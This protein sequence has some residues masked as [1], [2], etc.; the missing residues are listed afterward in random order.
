MLVIKNFKC[1]ILFLQ[2]ERTPVHFAAKDGH[3]EVIELLMK[4]GANI[5]CADEVSIVMLPTKNTFQIFKPF[6]IYILNFAIQIK[7]ARYCLGCTHVINAWT[8]CFSNAI[9]DDLKHCF[10]MVLCISIT[11]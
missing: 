9:F 10:T 5:N 2:H 7:S 11:T 6:V 8:E 4:H 3:V 1:V